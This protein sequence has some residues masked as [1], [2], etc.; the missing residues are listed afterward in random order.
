MFVLQ[1]GSDDMSDYV[2][3]RSHVAYDDPY[4]YAK[5]TAGIIAYP[6]LY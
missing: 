4:R 2:E 3:D 1:K 6:D 5:V